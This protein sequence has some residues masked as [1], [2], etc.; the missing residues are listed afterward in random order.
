MNTQRPEWNDANNA[1]VGNGVSMVTLYYLRRFFSFFET[2]LKESNFNETK[3]SEELVLFFENVKNTLENNKDILSNKISDKDRKTI[4]DGLGNA[5]S[6]YRNKIY[7]QKFSSNKK[8]ISKDDLLSFINTSL[9]F[10]DH[11]IRAN[12]RVDN[13]Y[14]AYNLMTITNNKEVSISYLS[15]MLEGQVAVLSSG[16]LSAKESVIVLNALKASKLF[17]EDQ[18]SYILYPN[19]ELPG[20]LD[21]NNIPKEKVEKSTLLQ[22]LIEK[23]NTQIIEQDCLDN[24]HFNGDFNNVESLKS[25][26]NELPLEFKKLKEQESSLLFDIFENIFNHKSFTGRS[27]T[28]YGYEGLGSIYWHMVSKL[29]LAVQEVTQNAIDN[30]EESE[31][32]GKLFD[33]YFEINEGIG[34]KKSPKLY[35]GFSNRPLFSHAFYKRSSTTWNDG[36]S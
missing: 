17:R 22:K 27:G 13:L 33:H 21:R 12:K 3:V 35:G 1:L 16:Y 29:Q 28:F 4:L 10:I 25:A 5:G 14:H 26:L 9:Q 30:K 18:Y 34:V 31:I 2:I 7:N 15:E 19:K 6:T 24:Y 8:N 11:S 36:A 20:F 23:G 32:I